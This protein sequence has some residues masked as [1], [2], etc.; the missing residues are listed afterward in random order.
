MPLQIMRQDITKL[1]VD[2]IVNAAN[3]SLLMGGGVCGAIFAA[4]GPE[5][6]QR[7]CDRIGHCETG[8]AV[9][10]PG[11]DLP[12]KYIIHT[13]GPVWRGGNHNERQL[14]ADCYRNSLR[15]AK[16]YR[17]KSVAFPLIASGI[18]GYPKGEALAVAI[19]AIGTF[20]L[21]EEIEV[22]LAVFDK[23]AYTLSDRL[24]KAVNAY[25]DQRYVD[26]KER[27]FGRSRY[28][29]N[30]VEADLRTEF[31]ET[32]EG[33]FEANFTAQTP[34]PPAP[35][36]AA[37]PLRKQA[38][39]E[40]AFPRAVPSAC[41]PAAP[42]KESKS[43]T[44]NLS[45]F[46]Q[47][48]QEGFSAQLMRHIDRKGLKDSDVYKRANLD[49]KLFSKIRSNPDYKPSKRTALAL[50]VALELN[51]DQTTDLLR[52]AGLALSPSS[53]G[54][55]IVQFFIEQG[56]YN[57]FEINEALFAFDENLLGA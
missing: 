54:D 6:L 35:C 11:F 23:A 30:A 25:I 1:N 27:F 17:L 15:L 33:C 9:I 36:K 22:I 16:K 21:E 19:E 44:L 26:D 56:N 13:P 42:E 14:L 4:A 7:A 2:A 55:L 31:F 24:F 37:A 28:L 10:T 49:R 39:M 32:D 20:L 18:Y 46:L 48:R 29:N 40:D 53:K 3:T 52:L 51:L 34:P 38:P 45:Q 47:R 41:A 8:Q 5:R 50:A 12:S 57:I 43:L